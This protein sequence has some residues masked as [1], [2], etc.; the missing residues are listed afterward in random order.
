[1]MMPPNPFERVHTLAIV[2]RED[3]TQRIAKSIEAQVKDCP[4]RWQGVCPEDRI[5]ASWWRDRALWVDSPDT[6]V[7]RMTEWD[8]IA[9][10]RNPGMRLLFQGA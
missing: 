8:G 10:I 2:Y 5:A 3:I 4:Q 1:M 9:Q 6:R 7:H